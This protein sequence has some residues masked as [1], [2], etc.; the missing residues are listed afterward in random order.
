MEESPNLPGSCKMDV[1]GQHGHDTRRF[2]PD[3]PR[4]Y[5]Q[6]VH[7]DGELLIAT[8]GGEIIVAAGQ[9]SLPIE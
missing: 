3:D 8:R 9:V 6:S 5:L 7:E 1:S 4:L 2:P